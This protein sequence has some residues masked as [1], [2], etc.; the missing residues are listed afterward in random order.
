MEIDF[1]LR[2]WQPL[3]S[4]KCVLA[5]RDTRTFVLSPVVPLKFCLQEV[6]RIVSN[7]VSRQPF[8]F[9]GDCSSGQNIPTLYFVHSDGIEG[10]SVGN[11]YQELSWS[12]VS[13]CRHSRNFSRTYLQ[14]WTDSASLASCNCTCLNFISSLYHIQGPLKGANTG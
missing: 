3:A 7:F 9:P 5:S 2:H 11:V 12:L 6:P 4:S 10:A 1:V 13:A 8:T 14:S